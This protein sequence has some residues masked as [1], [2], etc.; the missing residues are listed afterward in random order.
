MSDDESAGFHITSFI[1]D[2]HRNDALC[3][4][5]CMWWPYWIQSH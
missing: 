3:N 2:T 1:T 5:P 4:M